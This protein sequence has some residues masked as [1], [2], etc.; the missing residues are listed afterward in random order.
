MAVDTAAVRAILETDRA[1]AVYALADLAPE[2]SM[3]ARWRLAPNGRPALLL[4]Y[5]AFRPPVLFAHGDPAY[6]EPLLAG[7]A[8]E[9]EFYLSVR[10]EFAGLLRKAGYRVD[11]E[12]RMWR[13]LARPDDLPD[14]RTTAVPLGPGDRVALAELYSDGEAA[15]EAPSFFDA[16][17]LG[18][19]TYFGVR[20][21]DALVA[22]A[23]THV[24]APLEGV[25]AVGNVYTR[26]DRR[27]RGLGVRLPLP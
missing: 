17:M 7:I 19:G 2:Y 26:R 22:A 4:I 3:H 21:R 13:M 23:G 18:S 6:L 11:P 12:K 25:A 5:G 20:E 15:G 10:P 16:T 8:G 1:W 27:G 24:L 14:I 9:P